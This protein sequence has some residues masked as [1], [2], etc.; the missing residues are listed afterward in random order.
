[1]NCD[2]L[3]SWMTHL[4]EG[5]WISF[6][7]AVE[8]I[9]DRDC[10][11]PALNRTLRIRL[12]DLGFADFFIEDTQRWRV[13]PPILGGLTA[14]ESMVALYGSRTPML[15]EELRSAAEM[16]GCRFETEELQDCPTLI[17]VVGAS[18]EIQAVASQINVP[19]RPNNPRRVAEEAPPIPHI[20]ET[21]SE[22]PAPLNWQ[23]RAFDFK[24]NAWIDGLLPNAACE[25]TPTYGHPRYFIHK[26]HGRLL[27][28]SKRESL[29]A[30]A[31]LKGVQV[32]EYSSDTMNLSTPLFAPM[33]E[34]YARAAC[35]C[36]CRPAEILDGRITYGDVSPEV[37]ALLMVAAGQPHPGATVPPDEAR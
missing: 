12:S 24:T 15:A 22:E 9:A 8:E 30:A 10:D 5:T 37:A 13:L 29:Y 18:E 17:R 6:R 36:S 2:M 35:L 21:A 4:G 34:L 23:I 20:L 27:R 3:L 19:Y 33:P 16:H 25:F 7:K 31:M 28:I 11:L 14:Q 26:R 32:I 1:M